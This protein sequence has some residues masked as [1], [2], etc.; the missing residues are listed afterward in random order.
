MV[1][2][3]AHTRK[4]VRKVKFIKLRLKVRKSLM[5]DLFKDWKVHLLCIILTLVA[6]CIGVIKFSFG[7]LSFSLLPMLYALIF[8]LVL[9]V[10]KVIKMEEMQTASPYIGISVMLLSVKMGSSIGPQLGAVLKSGPA[11]LL[12]ELGN[13]GTVFL[14]IPVAC[15]VFKMGRAAVGCGFS[16]SREGSLAIIADMYSLDSPEGQGVMGGYMTGTILG[17]VFNGLMVS[18]LISLGIFHPYA[19]AMAAGTGS[20]SMMSAALAPIVE[21]YPRMAETLQAYAASSQVLTSVDGMY[22][23]LFVAIPLT[24]WLYGKLSKGYAQKDRAKAE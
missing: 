12:Q 11:L 7:P 4:K 14:A 5:K 19:L 20:A 6:E 22:M 8:G 3:I 16:I 2:H 24:N 21:A 18:F 9:G 15:L 1:Y 13:L 23:S 17:T 10:A